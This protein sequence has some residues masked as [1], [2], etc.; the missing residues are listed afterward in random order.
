M[1]IYLKLSFPCKRESKKKKRLGP[2][3]AS[4]AV[5]VKWMPVSASMTEE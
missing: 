3:F 4:M 2:S 5:K 1:G